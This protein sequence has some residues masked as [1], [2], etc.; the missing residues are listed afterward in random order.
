MEELSFPLRAS[1]RATCFVASSLGLFLV[2]FSTLTNHRRFI[3]DKPPLIDEQFTHRCPRYNYPHWRFRM[4][5]V[6]D[7]FDM[8]GSF[9]RLD[10]GAG[11]FPRGEE[12]HIINL[13]MAQPL[14]R[15]AS[16]ESWKYVWCHS[17]N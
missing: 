1:T 7:T 14:F 13:I 8:R 9:V 4:T 3:T 16:I 10:L 17:R 2:S 6:S 15:L 5:F 11:F 12:F